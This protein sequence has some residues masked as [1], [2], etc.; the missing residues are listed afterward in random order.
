MRIILAFFLLILSVLSFGQTVQFDYGG[1]ITN[2]ETGKKETGVKVTVTSNGVTLATSVTAS[3]GKYIIKFDSPAQSKYDIVFSKAGFVSKRVSFDLKDLNT[4]GMKDGL[5]LSPLEDLSLEI[6]PV[7]LDIDFSFLEN[8]PVALFTADSKSTN[9]KLD[10]SAS[11]RMKQ[12]IEGLLDNS[13]NTFDNTDVKYNDAITKGDSFFKE[14]KLEEALKQFEAAAFLK[15]KEFYPQKKIAEIDALLKA[16]TN[17]SYGQNETDQ[18]YNNYIK[19]ADNF[20]DEKKYTEALSKYRAAMRVKNEQY[21]KDEVAKIEKL[22]NELASAERKEREYLAAITAA[23]L[24]MTSKQYDQAIE[25]FITASGIKPDEKYPKDQLALAQNAL[26]ELA[27]K[28][29]LNKNYDAAMKEGASIFTQSKFA[30]AKAKYIEA[31]GLKPN[32]SMPKERIKMCD[33]Q[34]AKLDQAKK[35]EEEINSLFEQGQEQIDAKTYTMAKVTYKKIQSLDPKKNLAKVKLDEI[36]RFIK[37]DEDA[38]NSEARFAKFVKD[39]DAAVLKEDFASAKQ[40]Y[41][42]A[43]EVKQDKPVQDKFDSVVSKIENIEAK[44]LVKNEYDESMAAAKKLFD[45]NELEKARL[46]YQNAASIDPTQIEPKLRI[47]QI[48]ARLSKKSVEEKKFRALIDK[49]DVFV[50]QERYLEAIKEFD[51]AFE[52]RPTESEPKEKSAEAARLARE[53]K[54][55]D[56]RQFERILSAARTAIDSVDYKKATDLVNRAVTNRAPSLRPTDSRP[57]DML[58][59]INMLEIAQKN[60]DNLIATAENAEAADDLKTAIET[61]RKA[62]DIKPKETLP[63]AKIVELSNV[64]NDLF[65]AAERERKY[66]ENFKKGVSEM[67]IKSYN[68]ALASFQKAKTFKP[69]DQVVQDKISEVKQILDDLANALANDKERK[70]QVDALIKEA[71]GLFDTRDWSQAK[72]KYQQVVALD[73]EQPY[74]TS[75]IAE[76]DAKLQEEKNAVADADYKELIAQADNNFEK[77]DFLRSK[78]LF[79]KAN[80][81]RPSDPYPIKK[82]AELERILNPTIVKTSSLEALG[83]VYTGENSELDLVKAE[84]TRKNKKSDEFLKTKN[85]A[86]AQMEL[87][88]QKLQDKTYKTQ[89]DLNAVEAKSSEQKLV[90]E[91]RAH[92]N[93]EQVKTIQYSARAQEIEN[94]E[95]DKAQNLLSQ[96]KLNY[97]QKGLEVINEKQSAEVAQKSADLK[98]QA[99]AVYDDVSNRTEMYNKANINKGKQMSQISIEASVAMNDD[100]SRALTEAQLK[101][102]KENSSGQMELENQKLQ[103]KTYKTQADLNAVEAKS[104]EQKLVAEARAHDNVEQVKTIQYSARAQEIE[105]A[106][107]DKAQN[108]LSQEKL[109]YIQKGLEVINEKQSAEVAQK[110]ADL[111]YQASAVYD[112]VSNRTEMYNKANI[113]KGKQMSQISIEASVAMNDDES[114][115]LTEA[116][117][118]LAKENASSQMSTLVE[119]QQANAEHNEDRF[120]EIVSANGATKDAFDDK[121]KTRNDKIKKIEKDNLDNSKEAYN[122]QMEKYLQTKDQI[123]SQGKVNDRYVVEESGKIEETQMKIANLKKKYEADTEIRTTSG[124]DKNVDIQSNLDYIAIEELKRQEEAKAAQRDNAEIIKE[125]KITASAVDGKLAENKQESVYSAQESLDKVKSASQVASKGSSDKQMKNAGAVDDLYTIERI[126]REGMAIKAT[127]NQ[128]ETIEKLKNVDATPVKETAKNTL[129]MDFPEGVTEEQFSQSGTDGT[130]HTIITRRIVVIDGHGEVYI[131]TQRDG[132]ETFKKNDQPITKHTWQKETQGSNLVRH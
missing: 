55:N 13:A 52:M 77:K 19:A 80:S 123:A 27:D 56:N 44:V 120:R 95:Y 28:E 40:N 96:E 20:R 91:A 49:G 73:T 122:R 32:E 105:N 5:K 121:L 60:Y 69:D 22:T 65:S 115:S 89:A 79:E 53:S 104:S 15:P 76:C 108:L 94:A 42:A 54:E 82:L 18:Q 100:E 106:E 97:I 125:V 131:R 111:K 35:I 93:V 45:E 7:K 30:E 36:E 129:G 29:E 67:N 87:E 103:D 130:I 83:D 90:A 43:L 57:E 58:K 23:D 75:R 128:Q 11:Q 71:N 38:K 25:Q 109:N 116:Q 39:A 51:S 46:K 113:N 118:K 50:Q 81:S 59:E 34:L 6:F 119:D 102:A 68:L 70:A 63:P 24:A 3:N 66:A 9:L 10:V 110:S 114:R 126:R 31:S 86:L 8:E 48:D 4:D 14:K 37:A 17:E 99:S 127:K 107:Y 98:Y 88:N 72:L 26:K 101:L 47:D 64:Y 112:D 78:E 16:K 74:S 132:M 2:Y 62:G 92:D 61:Y 84:Q 33:D 41:G 124:K 117:L 12:K 21:P 1:Q 85:S